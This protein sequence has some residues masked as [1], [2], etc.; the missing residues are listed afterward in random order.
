MS[1][2]YLKSICFKK[3]G[4]VSATIA[5]SS[6]R[7]LGYHAVRIADLEEKNMTQREYLKKVVIDV[8]DGNFHISSRTN[9]MLN[10]ICEAQAYLKGHGLH[11]ILTDDDYAEF[12]AGYVM[13]RA[14]AVSGL[15]TRKDT[16]YTVEYAKKTLE[17]DAGR[18]SHLSEELRNNVELARFYVEKCSAEWFFK[19]PDCLLLDRELVLQ[20][21]KK[22]GVLFRDFNVVWGNDEEIVLAAFS[23]PTW[24][25]HL[26][27]LI[28]E[29]LLQNRD[30]LEKLIIAE[31]KLHWERFPKEV[32][33]DAEVQSWLAQY[34]VWYQEALKRGKIA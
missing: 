22:K 18:W 23:E 31:P 32:K 14:Q 3:D 5:D 34:N 2:Y 7:P 26:P 1:F 21:V 17:N 19:F 13:D 10:A 11:N 6:I 9:K 33:E 24:P 15:R 28:G 12:V 27:D 29:K 25:E 8:R 16:Y 20:T 4:T 30:F